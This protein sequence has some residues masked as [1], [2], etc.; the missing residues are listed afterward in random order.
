L[1]VGEWFVA[2]EFGMADARR[3]GKKPGL[4]L[5]FTCAQS[6]LASGQFPNVKRLADLEPE[7]PDDMR[8][9]GI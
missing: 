7:F 4:L 3:S 1:A 5:Q 2:M 9:S 6:V 8:S